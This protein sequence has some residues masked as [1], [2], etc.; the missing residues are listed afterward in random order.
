MRLI[1]ESTSSLAQWQAVLTPER[2]VRGAA[3]NEIAWQQTVQSGQCA[4]WLDFPAWPCAIEAKGGVLWAQSASAKHGGKRRQV[5]MPEEKTEKQ[6]SQVPAHNSRIGWNEGVHMGS[7]RACASWDLLD[8]LEWP[9]GL[10]GVR[11]YVTGSVCPTFVTRG[12]SCTTAHL[13]CVGGFSSLVEGWKVFVWWDLDDHVKMGC[14]VDNLFF[15][16]VAAASAAF[17]RWALLGPGSTISVCADVPYAVIT[18]TSSVL[19]T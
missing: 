7:R 4:V 2:C 9:T 1:C 18:L 5:G 17:F 19:F 16:V 15:S 11:P 8:A 10:E 3:W 6:A 13:D 14:K 12:P